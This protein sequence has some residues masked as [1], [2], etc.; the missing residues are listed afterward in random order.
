MSTENIKK[1]ML[2]LIALMQANQDAKVSAIMD[3]AVAIASTKSRGAKKGTSVRTAI[4]GADNEVLAIRDYYFQRWMP[5]VGDA[6][7]EF[8][9]KK[10]SSTGYNSMSKEG[11]SNWTKQQAAAKKALDQILTD[12]ESGDLDPSDISD[13]KAEIEAARKEVVATDLGFA[14]LEEAQEYL[15]A[16]GYDL[17]EPEAAAE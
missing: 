15:I 6:A 7:V 1:T 5:L 14:T 3:E 13:R 16:E 10:G 17:S 2:P 9:T 12:V 4:R 11:L 8:G